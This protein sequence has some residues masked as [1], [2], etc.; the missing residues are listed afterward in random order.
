MI[1]FYY[2]GKVVCSM[3]VEGLTIPQMLTGREMIASKLK[4]SKS[5]IDFNC[6][7]EGT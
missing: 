7:E 2:K 6:V 3:P 4:V 1:R 5:C